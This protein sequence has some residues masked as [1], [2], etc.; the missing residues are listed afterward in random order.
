MVLCCGHISLADDDY[1]GA[2]DGKNLSVALHRES[3]DEE[4][5]WDV[6]VVSRRG[7]E[8]M[9][10]VCAAVCSRDDDSRSDLDGEDL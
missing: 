5:M 10:S 3:W 2:V 9:D 1:L 8:D 4:S 6:F 7:Q